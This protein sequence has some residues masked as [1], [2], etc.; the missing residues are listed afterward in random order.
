M[1]VINI[2][3]YC[4]VFFTILISSVYVC[5]RIRMDIQTVRYL[6]NDPRVVPAELIP[7]II[8][9][10]TNPQVPDLPGSY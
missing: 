5:K 7:D 2:I 3:I 9:I 6:T 8:I 10:R 1:I 4:V